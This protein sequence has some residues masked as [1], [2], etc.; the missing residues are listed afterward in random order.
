MYFKDLFEVI[1]VALSCMMV[2]FL[3]GTCYD[4]I[5]PKDVKPVLYECD[6]KLK[7]HTL[8]APCTIRS[9]MYAV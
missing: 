4:S 1:N 5:V 6:F 9:K 2:V 8:T 7:N 3:F